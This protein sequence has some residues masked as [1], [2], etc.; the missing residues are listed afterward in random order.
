[1]SDQRP[2]NETPS[3]AKRRGAGLIPALLRLCLFLPLVSSSSLH[4]SQDWPQFRGPTGQG[5]SSA[6]NVPVSWGA[7]SNVL[8]KVPV[9]GRGWSSPTVQSGR[10]YLTS[11]VSDGSVSLRTLC[12]DM[13]T[14][15]TLWMTEAIQPDDSETKAAHKKNSL[16]SPTPLLHEGRVYAHFGH[17]GTVCLDTN[18][19]ILW[20]NQELKYAPLHGN[21]GSPV[22]AGGL[23]IFNADAVAEPFLAALDAS[24]GKVR[25]KVPRTAVVKKRFSFSTPLVIDLDGRPQLISAGSGMVG[26]FDPENGRE[27]WRVLYGEGFSVIPRPV[28]AHGLLFV[29]SGYTQP[30][31]HAINPRGAAGDVTETH[32]AWTHRKGVPHTAS[33]LALGQELYFVSDAGIATCV[34]A[35]SGTE[36]WSER[37]GGDFSASPVAAE[38]RIYF[39]NE[40]G[41]G[42]VVKASRQFELISKNELGER[43]LASPAVLD[44]TLL[45]RSEAHLWRIGSRSGL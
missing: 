36:L 15:Q 37:L 2:L 9:P 41:I 27:I 28:Y 3:S 24:H 26:G 13:E 44:G 12:F 1:M 42:F 40:A 11:A 31:L 34:E 20:T 22:L 29:A 19:V 14:G 21:G 8:W 39:L 30:E 45:L 35:R 10:V 33:A 4:A 25:W 18:G 38:G 6:T 5:L 7:S 23:L 16:A 17:M 43:A 32:R